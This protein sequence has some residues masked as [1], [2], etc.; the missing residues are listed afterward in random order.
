MADEIKCATCAKGRRKCGKGCLILDFLPEAE[1]KGDY[2]CVHHVFTLDYFKNWMERVNNDQREELV[3]SLTWD[4]GI[5]S[6]A[7][8]C[9][10]ST[11]DLK[12]IYI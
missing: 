6:E 9:A 10:T 11:C 5:Y 8:S 2:E 1:G 7:F 12:A 3:E 4:A